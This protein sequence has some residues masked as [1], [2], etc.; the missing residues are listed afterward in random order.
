[1]HSV[2]KPQCLDAFFDLHICYSCTKYGLCNCHSCNQHNCILCA[3]DSIRC[4]TEG[5][6]YSC[7]CYTPRMGGKR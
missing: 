6:V 5:T 4:D 7:D 1:M 2:Q 3:D